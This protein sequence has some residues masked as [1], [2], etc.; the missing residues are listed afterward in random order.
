MLP[1]IWLTSSAG[2]G[3]VVLDEVA[4]LE[5]GDLRQPVADLHAHQVAADRAA[6]ALAAPTLD[7]C[8]RGHGG[9][10]ATTAPPA[11]RR[12][13]APWLRRRRLGHGRS[14]DRRRRASVADL[15]FAHERALGDLGS[16]AALPRALG[17]LRLI[18]GWG[19]RHPR[20]SVAIG[21]GLRRLRRRSLTATLTAAGTA[22][23]L[24][25]GRSVGAVGA[26]TV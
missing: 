24:A 2:P 22:A 23:A 25:P 15:R 13:L 18:G 5:H 21:A 1:W 20:R 26:I 17:Q 12:L 19:G 3:H 4:A 16:E 14:G 8:H 9:A 11:P 6:L 10:L 7:R